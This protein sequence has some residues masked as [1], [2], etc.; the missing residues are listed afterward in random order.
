LDAN[1]DFTV[2]RRIPRV[3]SAATTERA[4]DGLL[5]G[6]GDRRFEVRHRCGVALA[7]LHERL[8]DVV[9]GR[10]AILAV[11]V[12][13]AKVDRRVWERQRP[14][15]E[16]PEEESPFFDEAIRDRASRSLEHIFTML[17]LV[18]PRRPLEIA[19]RGLYAS[20][21]SLRGTALEYLEVILPTE[22][23]EA[24]WSHIEDRRPAAPTEKSREE[25]LDSLLRSHHS[26]EIDLAEIRKRA[27]GEG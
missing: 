13:E 16:S 18:L 2:R 3:L 22:I 8:P 1:E 11:V 26:I 19:Y 5:R 25:V 10:E 6:L 9:I 21:A 27:R 14:L 17:S 23:R 4:V 20:D 15:H 24:I 12:R 7:R